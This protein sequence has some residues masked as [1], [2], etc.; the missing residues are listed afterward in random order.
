[1][2]YQPKLS[3]A[4]AQVVGVEALVRW[5]HPQLG[6]LLPDAFMSLVREHGLMQRVTELVLDR[7][8]DDSARWAALGARTPVAVNLFAASVRD[9]GLPD[10]L[11]RALGR[12]GLPAELLTVE[13]TEDLVVSEIELVT[14]VLRRLRE[15][16]IRVAIDDFGSGYSSLSYLHDLPVDEIK[17]DRHFVAP[18]CT[19]IRAGAVVAAVIDLAHDLGI[20]V[21]AEGI[22]DSATADWLRDHGC[23]VG[24]GYLFGRPVAAG[25]IPRCASFADC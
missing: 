17:L 16:G 12:R 8:L 14:A 22:E 10:M 4:T 1:M 11:C 24:Q 21:V 25:R 9:R 20:I 6:T 19:D 2:V 18:V 7:V 23:D 3:L 13:I 5:P 15:H